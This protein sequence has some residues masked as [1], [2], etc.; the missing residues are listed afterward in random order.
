MWKKG[1]LIFLVLTLLIGLT[2]QAFAGSITLAVNGQ[3][4][5]KDLSAQVLLGKVFVPLITVTEK[6]GGQYS[7][8]K[9]DNQAVV[10]IYGKTAT[11]KVGEPIVRINQV[12]RLADFPAYILDGSLMV[13]LETIE[14]IFD[15]QASWNKE[16][17][18]INLAEKK[19]EITDLKVNRLPGEAQVLIV[20]KKPL[21]GTSKYL[22]ESKQIVLEFKNVTNKIGKDKIE[23]NDELVKEIKIESSLLHSTT[24]ITIYLQKAVEH[25]LEKGSGENTLLLN[26]HE[27]GREPVDVPNDSAADE[28]QPLPINEQ[29]RLVDISFKSLPDKD[30][31]YFTTNGQTKVTPVSKLSNPH[32]LVLD[33]NNTKLDLERESLPVNDQVIKQIRAGQFTKEITRVVID[34]HNDAKYRF[35]SDLSGSSFL[36]Q[37][38]KVPH[39]DWGIPALQGKVIVLDP[40]HG[41]RDPGAIGP[42]GVKEKDVVLAVAQKLSN[43]LLEAGAWPLLTRNSDVFVDLLSRVNLANNSKADLFVSIHGNAA[44]IYNAG[45]T[46][47]YSYIYANSQEGVRLAKSVQNNLVRNLGLLNRGA[48]TAN[49]SVLRNSTMPSI[50]AELAFLSNPREEQLLK[51]SAFQQKAAEALMQGIL[52]YYQQ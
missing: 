30:Q 16:Q 14:R 7:W 39:P 12:P 2:G 3:S 1:L 8:N 44:P 38:A 10:N 9:K 22:P 15:V 35:S 24:Q 47:T 46:E 20:S 37:V 13:S 48:K 33:F 45:G 52:D 27:L 28:Q 43:L 31:I 6:M 21:T 32:R 25:R 4:V 18:V 41:G 49:F 36:L 50:L 40:G 23:V 34:L 26:I 19:P 5:A 11:M 51:D 29:A 17:A 42:T